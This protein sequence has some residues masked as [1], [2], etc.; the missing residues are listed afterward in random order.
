MNAHTF[1]SRYITLT[2]ML[3]DF[4][5]FQRRLHSG[6]W[7]KTQNHNYFKGGSKERAKPKISAF[8]SVW[9]TANRTEIVTCLMYFTSNWVSA[10]MQQIA[11]IQPQTDFHTPFCWFGYLLNSLCLFSSVFRSAGDPLEERPCLLLPSAD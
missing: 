7:K 8:L 10:K 6:C 3:G 2:V 11:V 9:L 4:I 1:I 5:F